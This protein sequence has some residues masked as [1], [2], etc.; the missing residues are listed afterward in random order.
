MSRAFKRVGRQSHVDEVLTTI[1]GSWSD[2]ILLL[3]SLESILFQ[4]R[5]PPTGTDCIGPATRVTLNRQFVG[6]KSPGQ[7]EP[8]Q[9]QESLKNF[10]TPAG[11]RSPVRTI[12]LFELEL[13][14]QADVI[15]KNAR[16]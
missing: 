14:F 3:T 4:H 11:Y 16:R 9:P 6:W 12:D 13:G 1:V 2:R 10:S 5:L 7:S 8:Q 15:P